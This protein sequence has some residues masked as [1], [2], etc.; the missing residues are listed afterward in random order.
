MSIETLK[1]R[2]PDYAKDLKLNLSSLANDITLSPQ[3][4][5]GT[6]VASAIASRNAD[7]TRAIVAEYES[8]LSPQALTA[9]K[10]AAA[11]MG[12]N[13]IYYR[14]VHMVEGDYAHMPARLRMNVIGRPGVEKLDFELWS[15]AV[16]AIN[17]CGMCVESHEKVVREGGLSAEQVQT[18]VRVAA[19]VHAVAAT[20]DGAAA[21][22]DHPA[23]G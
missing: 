13:N 16:S 21:L 7:V 22:G 8:V 10:A 14:F 3:Q 4:L 19:T 2:L 17:G 5:A 12:L 20:L 11:I 6:F 18:A 9:A 1:E 15:L 23:A